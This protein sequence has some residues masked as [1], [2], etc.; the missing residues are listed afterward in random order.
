MINLARKSLLMVLIFVTAVAS[1]YFAYRAYRSYQNYHVVRSSNIY[2][3]FINRVDDAVQELEKERLL[4]SLYLGYN[5]KR[6]FRQLAL[7]R[8]KSDK[9]LENVFS[10]I[11]HYSQMGSIRKSFQNIREDLRYVRSRVDVLNEDYKNLLFS[12]Y[13]NKTI[14]PLMQQSQML[15]INLSKNIGSIAN[16]FTTYDRL[17]NMR[18]NLNQEQSY[19]AY[20]LAKKEKMSMSDLVTWENILKNEQFPYLKSLL[21]SPLYEPVKKSLH[22]NELNTS[23]RLLRRSILQGS[24]SGNYSVDAESW[25]QK[26]QQNI[27]YIRATANILYDY[28]KSFDFKSIM[29]IALYTNILAAVAAILL[30]LFLYKYY[31]NTKK[32]SVQKNQD[33][34]IKHLEVYTETENH[35]EAYAAKSIP[36]NQNILFRQSLHLDDTD[37]PLTNIADIKREMPE[38][39]EE[40]IVDA[41]LTLSKKE[42]YEESGFSPIKLF[43]EIIKPYVAIS[44]QRNISFHYAIDPSLPDICL[45]D[46]K[47]IKKI[48][49]IFLDIAMKPRDFRKEVT[50][51]IENIAQKKFDTAL[52]I[53]IKDEG[54]HLSSEE[55]QK[56]RNGYSATSNLLEET[57][58][59][60][61]K[62]FLQAR[63]LVKEMLGTLQVQSDSKSGTRFII[64]LT[65][66]QFISSE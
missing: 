46:R 52:A 42:V 38:K 3:G 39:M 18:D 22:T 24:G 61:M 16:Y 4:T 55:R 9:V 1:L 7:Q 41:A 51:H 13:Q 66:K 65:L 31:K 34:Q 48:L 2:I 6:D 58:S 62:D 28:I 30:L 59:P 15:L 33:I 10:Y 8:E 29:P 47:K 45:G 63:Q 64:S 12:Y 40:E 23:L 44:Q 49:M 54:I 56:I 36:I 11:A 19:I 25:S 14:A 37:I 60:N 27:N 57:F 50:I 20:I 5:G 43:K 26:I 21:N 35:A 53:T 32:K 17:I